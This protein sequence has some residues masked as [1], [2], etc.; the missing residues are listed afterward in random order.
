ML[1]SQ[2]T[3][4]V[5][6]TAVTGSFVLLCLAIIVVGEWKRGANEEPRGTTL[7]CGLLGVVMFVASMVGSVNAY[8]SFAPQKATE[9]P[10]PNCACQSQQE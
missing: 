2:Q 6:F 8:H 3:F 7:V 9:K 1:T 10:R 5:C 4:I